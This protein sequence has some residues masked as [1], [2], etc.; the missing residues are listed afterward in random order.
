VLA[1]RGVHEEPLLG[2]LISSR[3]Q[4]LIERRR[5][6]LRLKALRLGEGVSEKTEPR[7]GSQLMPGHDRSACALYDQ[8]HVRGLGGNI[9]HRAPFPTASISLEIYRYLVNPP[10]PF[11][12]RGK[13]PRTISRLR[14]RG[15]DPAKHSNDRVAEEDDTYVPFRGLLD[16]EASARTAD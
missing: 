3:L 15:D 13:R 6:K 8:F 7:A 9:G 10:F 12:S 5:K 16:P 14:G 2:A 1:E 4:R 11:A